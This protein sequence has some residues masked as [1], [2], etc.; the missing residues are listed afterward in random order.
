MV[1]LY[2]RPRLQSLIPTRKPSLINYKSKYILT[3]THIWQI[4]QQYLKNL[5]WIL[6]NW[7]LHKK[8]LNYS[9][10]I[11][12]VSCYV[13]SDLQSSKP[14][15]I[16][17][18]WVC[19]ELLLTHNFFLE[20]RIWLLVGSTR[21]HWHRMSVFVHLR[22]SGLSQLSTCWGTYLMLWVSQQY[23]SGGGSTSEK[24]LT[25]QSEIQGL[26]LIGCA[27]Q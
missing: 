6:N 9:F 26:T 24:C 15:I 2:N 5:F 10:Y 12:F 16:R 17:K 18:M 7:K 20:T 22:S 13:F 14:S 25:F 27:Y 23:A 21:S 3:R 1:S 4:P 19:Y 8:D 11:V